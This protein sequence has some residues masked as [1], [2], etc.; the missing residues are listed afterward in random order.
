MKKMIL[1]SAML[2]FATLFAA[3]MPTEAEGS[4]YEDTVRLHILAN[5]DSD[6]DQ[7]LKLRLRDA[8]LK[9]YG[10]LLTKPTSKKEAEALLKDRLGEIEEFCEEFL[11]DE[12]YNYSI[13]A[14]LGEELYDT[15]NYGAISLPRGKYTSLR[16]MIGEGDG[17]NWWC[18]MYP[19]LC[20]DIATEKIPRNADSG[21]TDAER[22]LIR[23]RYTVK[24]KLLEL[25]SDAF[26]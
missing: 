19:P 2:L 20:L 12:G 3:A 13:R 1:F 26:S 8:L 14:E 4:V 11:R 5:S 6:E 25:I 21:Y 9:K 7:E 24:F 15:R 23:G 17:E 22:G 18:V 16:I 10:V